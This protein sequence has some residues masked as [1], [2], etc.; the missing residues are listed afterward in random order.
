MLFIRLLIA[1]ASGICRPLTLQ[2]QENCRWSP[3]FWEKSVFFFFFTGEKEKE[4]EKKEVAVDL[5]VGGAL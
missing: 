4:R 2:I 1:Q 3:A 5:K